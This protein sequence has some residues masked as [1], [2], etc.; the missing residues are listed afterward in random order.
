MMKDR[1]NS[2]LKEILPLVTDYDKDTFTV[3]WRKRHKQCGATRP[4]SCR[5]LFGMNLA[6][7]VTLYTIVIPA[8]ATEPSQLFANDAPAL[9]GPSEQKACLPKR[10][11]NVRI[12]HHNHQIGVHPCVGRFLAGARGYL[13]VN[14]ASLRQK[15]ITN[16]SPALSSVVVSRF[17]QFC[18][19]KIAK[20][21]PSVLQDGWR[22]TEIDDGKC[23]CGP[24]I[25]AES[26]IWIN[27]IKNWAL[28]AY[29]N[30]SRPYRSIS[31][32]FGSINLALASLPQSVGG[33]LQADSREP[34]A[35][36]RD[37]EN[38]SESGNNDLVVVVM[39]DEFGNPMSN[40]DRSGKEGGESRPQ[41]S[42]QDDKWS[43]CLTAGTLCPANQEKQ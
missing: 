5:G 25:F 3:L 29:G 26:N 34:K 7:I 8:F 13:Q 6:V 30:G 38:Y 36:G 9:L 37:G 21:I 43:F 24:P 2:P 17:W 14:Y 40:N 11:E 31:R 39:P 16:D 18:F 28:Y 1:E 22:P 41:E 10:S 42:A 27:Y 35:D 32:F 33:A 4:T 20:T 19:G 15:S 12:I 23:C